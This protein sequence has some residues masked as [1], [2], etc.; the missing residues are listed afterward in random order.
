M[1]RTMRGCPTAQ[2]QPKGAKEPE[3]NPSDSRQEDQ[4]DTTEGKVIIDYNRDID[5]EGT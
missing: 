5:D 4:S 2:T 1:A 3:T